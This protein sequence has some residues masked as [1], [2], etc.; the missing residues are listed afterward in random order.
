MVVLSAIPG[1]VL[2]EAWWTLYSAGVEL[3]L[4]MCKTINFSAVLFQQPLQFPTLCFESK[5]EKENFFSFT[6][7]V[8]I[9]SETG[10]PYMHKHYMHI[11]ARYILYVIYRLYT[12]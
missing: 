11:Y 1:Y 9:F 8:M 2:R 10:G 5:F 12:I 3:E 7:S 6:N 4:A